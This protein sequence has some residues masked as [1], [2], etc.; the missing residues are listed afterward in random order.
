MSKLESKGKL[1]AQTEPNPKHTVFAITTISGTTYE[2]PSKL[3]EKEEKVMGDGDTEANK[4]TFIL[5]Q[6][7]YREIKIQA[8]FPGRLR[9]TK[10]ER[11]TQEIM[12]TF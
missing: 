7:V 9:T 12:S 1:P 6:P 4:E 11:E 2:T 5:K 10:R 8:P 3:D